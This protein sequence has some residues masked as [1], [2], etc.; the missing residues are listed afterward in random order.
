VRCGPLRRGFEVGAVEV[1]FLTTR[2]LFHRTVVRRVL[3][4][5]APPSRAIESFVDLSKGDHVVHLAHGVAR[6]LGMECFEK[7]NVLQEFLVLEFRGQLK[8]YVPVSKADLVQKYIGPGDRAPVLDRVGGSSW[9]RKKEE[10]EEALLDLASEL[11]EVQAMREERPGFAA[12]LDSEWQRQFEAAFP[13]E[14]TPDQVEVTAAIKADMQSPRPMD[15]LICGDV[16][17]GKT[18]LAMRAA[19]K[20]VDA[21]KQVAMLVPTT[22]LAQQHFHTF[23]ERMAE[24]PVTIDVISRFRTASEQK[25]VV[26]AARAGQLDVLIGTHRILS[27][28]IG[29]RDLGLVIIDEEQRFGVEHKERLKKLRSTVDVL[30]LSATPIP[31]TLHMALLG[32]RD[33]SSLTTAPQ[34]RS[35][36][37]TEV[38][39]YEPGLVREAV[40]RELNRDGQVYFVHNRIHDIARVKMELEQLVPEARIEYA[41]GQMNEHELEDKMVRFVLGEIDVLISTTIIESGIDIPNVNTIFIDEADIYGLADLHQLRGRVGRYKHQAYCYLV[42]PAHRP[43]NEDAEKRLRALVEFSDLGAGFQIALRDL[44]IRGAGNILGPAQSGHI[45]LVGYDM[46]CRLLE[47][48][49]RRLKQ[50]EGAEPLQVEVDLALEAFIPEQFMAREKER[51]EVYRRLSQAQG[52]EALADLAAE[53]EDRFGPLPAPLTQLLEVQELRVLCAQHGIEYL[54]REGEHLILRGREPMSRLLE[55]SPV[56]VAVL[57]ART[58]AVSLAAARGGRAGAIGDEH[59]LR[60]GLAWLASGKFPLA[61]SGGTRQTAHVEG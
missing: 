54:G 38:C 28:D 49:V 39:R 51:L 8:L 43:V 6:Y 47:K 42:L 55:G 13:F 26:E 25:R 52:K 60:T 23:K 61:H 53:L 30:T 32:I 2:E 36:V 9:S 41:H 29:F 12:P 34:G 7:D 58:R 16:G 19:F 15:R 31:R 21:G 57:D 59:A 1:I 20:A 37:A 4:G 50:E 3:K 40:I 46:Y 10:V 33:I 22:V 17:Y 18:E 14:D 45:A 44:E 11:I 56:R 27:R 48:A 35:P 5:R 24:F